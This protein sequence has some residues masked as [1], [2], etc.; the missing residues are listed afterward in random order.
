MFRER[1]KDKLYRVYVTDALKA[2]AEMFS[3]VY[4]GSL[5]LPRYAEQIEPLEPKRAADRVKKPEKSADEIIGSISEKL[6]LWSKWN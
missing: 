5:S 3:S 6:D 4:G 1:A 2:L